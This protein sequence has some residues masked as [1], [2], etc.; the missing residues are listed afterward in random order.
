LELKEVFTFTPKGDMKTLPVGSTV[1]DFAYELHTKIGSQCIGAKVNYNIVPNNYVLKNGDQIEIITS[2]K[3]TP[4]P[5]WF[6]CVKTSKAREAIKEAIREEYKKSA[7]KGEQRLK[8]IFEELGVENNPQNI[9]KIQAAL[10]I[11]SLV[12][13]WNYVAQDKLTVDKTKKILANE[14]NVELEVFQK[15]VSEE[16]ANRSLDE[17]I[18]EQLETNPDIFTLDETTDIIKH[19]IASCCNPLPGDQVV[20][21]QISHDEIVVHQ[22]SCPKA[23][24]QMSKF[25][26]RIIK[27]KWSKEQDI[28][29]LSG[30]RIS[31][32]D[33]KGMI[34]DI[35]NVISEQLDLNIRSLQIESKGGIFN[36]TI[37]LYIQNVKTLTKLIETLRK[38]DNIESIDRIG[39]ELD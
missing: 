32:F 27:A 14:K 16:I 39:Y 11:K 13:F 15:R 33:K 25:G 36:S 3:Q 24:E 18:Y 4:K 34:R 17:L 22:T 29:F 5:E 38:I 8:Q 9:S 35:I 10:K 1:L 28:A 20:G 30:I 31:G 6:N 23:K 2:K 19:T 37:M 21:F 12:E 26:N 7:T